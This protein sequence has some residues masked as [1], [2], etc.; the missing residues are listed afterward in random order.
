MCGLA[1]IFRAD[2]GAIDAPLL[3]RM[4]GAIRH[5]GPDGDGFHVER[6]VGLGHRRLSIIDVQGGHQ[7]M[8]N[9]DDT[10]AIVFNG[11]IYNFEAL[12]PELEALGHVF[13]TRCD[14]E[15]ILH[16]WES[17]GPDCLS[18]LN[19]MFTLAI[20]DR[21]RGQLFLAR[22]RMGK[23][24]LYYA[25][26]Q[27]G[28]PGGTFVF[29]S[30]LC[31]LAEVP[32]LDRRLSPTAVED[33]FAYGYIPDPATIY[34]GV[35]KLPAAHFLLLDRHNDHAVPRRYWDV[36]TATHAIAEDE[37]VAGL[38]ERL[39]ACTASRLISDVPL[40]AF[41]SGGVDSSGIVATAAQLKS[42]PLSTFTIGF[43]GAEDE[44]PYAEMM[45]ARYGTDQHSEDAA[46]VDYI[47]AARDQARVFGEPFGDR[48]SVPTH[49]VCALARKHVT[50]AVS[51]DG[52]DEVFA[53]YRRY[54]WHVMTEAVR[55]Y[56]PA[57]LRRTVLGGVAQ[58]Y[59]KLD[60]APRWLRAK[61]TLTEI[62]LD[63]ALGYYRMVVQ[64][65][66]ERRHALLSPALRAGLDGYD[67]AARVVDLMEAANTDDPLVQ[68]Q[69][70]DIHTWLVGDILTKVDRASMANSLE[71]RAPFLDYEF[72]SWGM[73]LPA[74]LKLRGK[75]GKWVLKRALEPYVPRE[76]LYRTKQGFAATLG[77]AFRRDAARLRERL[78]GAAMLDSGVFQ[79]EAIGRLIDE[80]ERGRFDHSAP[81]WLLLVF[82]GFLVSELGADGRVTAG[83]G[84]GARDGVTVTA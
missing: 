17:W 83:A 52:G 59:P 14:T 70:A 33:Y 1:G 49:A 31:A 26:V 44:R 80:H 16:A 3:A 84:G 72:V 82:E 77:P 62:S 25:R 28:A 54:R 23:K 74:S 22:D 78:L 5:R 21:N 29:A 18:R 60:W 69:Y 27:D 8:Y 47:A 32:G 39:R 81:L 36:P 75:E 37:A 79:A 13:R 50:V 76:I 7:P 66:A 51:G 67:P 53:G 73:G 15:A 63:S 9:E 30:E 20:W 58:V 35:H 19:G 12:R 2:M 11:E 45:A 48:S 6:G 34:E 64:V 42:S 56:V 10:V 55:R 41:L 24:P 4:T 38:T 68:A 61:H 46:A 65:H 71:V 57:G 43:P 40:G